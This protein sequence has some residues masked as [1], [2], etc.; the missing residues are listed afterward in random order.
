MNSTRVRWRRLR[1]KSP[2]FGAKVIES[3]TWYRERSVRRDWKGDREGRTRVT[4]G[5]GEGD[6]ASLDSI[7]AVML[8]LFVYR[9][10][11]EGGSLISMHLGV[12]G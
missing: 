8:M 2:H 9:E 5:F 3:V 6:S 12:P 10:C 11:K 1:H 4:S 7:G